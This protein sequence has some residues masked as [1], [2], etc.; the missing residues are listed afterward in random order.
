[1]IDTSQPV[2]SLLDHLPP[3]RA[4]LAHTRRLAAEIEVTNPSRVSAS[5]RE[6]ILSGVAHVLASASD[7]WEATIH[8]QRYLKRTVGLSGLPVQVSFS[9]SSFAGGAWS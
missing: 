9:M 6:R 1:M 2:R 4:S 8:L 7:P 3:V 5:D